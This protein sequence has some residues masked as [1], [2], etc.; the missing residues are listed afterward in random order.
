VLRIVTDYAGGYRE[1]L[2]RTTA[3]DEL[4][5]TSTDPELLARAAAMHAVADNWY[6]I[7]AVDLLLDAGAPQPL[8]E[9]YLDECEPAGDRALA[10][11][12]QGVGR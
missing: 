6:A 2:G 9:R 7:T 11:N 1:G 10:A 5:A 12:D 4:A 3:L 8:M